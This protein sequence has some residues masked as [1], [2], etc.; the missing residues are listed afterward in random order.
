MKKH[1]Q[2]AYEMLSPIPYLHPSLDI[3]YC[4]HEHWDGSGYPRGLSGYQIPR[5][6]RL[7]TVVDVW[8]ALSSERPNRAAWKEDEVLHYL[9]EQSGKK[10]DPEFVTLFLDHYPEEKQRQLL[11]G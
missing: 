3:P 4:H 2:Y 8:D 11:V 7:F 9:K 1:P 6:A 10:L 5:E